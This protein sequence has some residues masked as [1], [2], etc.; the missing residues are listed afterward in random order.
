MID[1]EGAE[2]ELFSRNVAWINLFP[3]LMIELHDW[4]LCGEAASQTFLNAM[5]QCRRDFTFYGDTVFS[6]RC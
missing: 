3:L 1:I 4:M 2:K 5:A 6:I